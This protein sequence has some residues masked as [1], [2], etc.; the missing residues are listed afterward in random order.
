M[1]HFQ[2]GLTAVLAVA[3][4]AVFVVREIFSTLRTWAQAR[5]QI[6]EQRY[7]APVQNARAVPVIQLPVL[8][9]TVVVKQARSDRWRA[10]CR[11][12]NVT[13]QWFAM[14]SRR[15]IT[16]CQSFVRPVGGAVVMATEVTGRRLVLQAFRVGLEHVVH[17]R[18]IDNR[19]WTLDAHWRLGT[20][21]D[22]IKCFEVSPMGTRV[23]FS[24]RPKGGK[25]RIDHYPGGVRVAVDTLVQ[26]ERFVKVIDYDDKTG[27]DVTWLLGRMSDPVNQNA[28]AGVEAMP[29]A[30]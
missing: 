5:V 20:V 9:E 23:S 13:A 12:L 19:G 21:S 3:F 4:V 17:V 16:Q 10:Y 22:V 25:T 29:N 26:G 18:E 15:I 30:A 24:S 11:W 6:E 7:L 1:T 14:S 27:R 28:L 2:I 8:T